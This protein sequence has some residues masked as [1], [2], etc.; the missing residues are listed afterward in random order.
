MEIRNSIWHMAQ[1]HYLYE[2]T[3]NVLMSSYMHMANM[4]EALN[5]AIVGLY[6]QSLCMAPIT[7]TRHANEYD[8]QIPNVFIMIITRNNVRMTG[9]SGI[10]L[11][12]HL[13]IAT[14]SVN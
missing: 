14:N 4:I 2:T 10:W 1:S 12:K 8:M 3:L 11:H 7:K 6:Q 5:I 13:F 9:P